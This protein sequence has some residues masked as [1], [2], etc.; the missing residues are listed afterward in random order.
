MKLRKRRP[1]GSAGGGGGGGGGKDQGGGGSGG[2]ESEDKAAVEERKAEEVRAFKANEAARIIRASCMAGSRIR[3][4][5]HQT[6][7]ILEHVSVNE[8]RDGRAVS[9]NKATT[10]ISRSRAHRA[11]QVR[12]LGQFSANIDPY[13]ELYWRLWDGDIPAGLEMNPAGELWERGELERMGRG[14][15]CLAGA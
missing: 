5:R 1:R 13:P 7:R 8:R 3:K 10:T 2:G 14:L 15:P 4:R 12:K 6:K 9:N 11:E